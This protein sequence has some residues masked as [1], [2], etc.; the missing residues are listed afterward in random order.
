MHAHRLNMASGHRATNESKKNR[1]VSTHMHARMYA[2]THTYTKIHTHTHFILKTHLI[3][4]TGRYVARLPLC[5]RRTVHTV[6]LGLYHNLPG[7]L[8]HR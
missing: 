8:L 3:A 2:R 6:P 7:P 5:Q 1:Q 4:C